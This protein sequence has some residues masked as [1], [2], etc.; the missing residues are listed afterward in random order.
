[1]NHIHRSVLGVLYQ[2]L[3]TKEE[4]EYLSMRQEKVAE[5]LPLQVALYLTPQFPSRR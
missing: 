5:F 4:H 3:E 2:K 1:M